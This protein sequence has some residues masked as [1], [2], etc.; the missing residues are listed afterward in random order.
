MAF[1]PMPSPLK[2]SWLGSVMLSGGGSVTAVMAAK[3]ACS[4]AGSGAGA[5]DVAGVVGLGAPCEEKRS[6][7]VS[8]DSSERSG[9]A[10][11]GRGR[12]PPEV[13]ERCGYGGVARIFSCSRSTGW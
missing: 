8:D 3:A 4:A 6:D 1:S 9:V 2:S 10:G 13:A 12:N 5:G 7:R 11:P